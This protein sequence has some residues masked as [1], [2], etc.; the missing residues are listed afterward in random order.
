MTSM[1]VEVKDLKIGDIVQIQE[2]R[3]MGIT[4]MEVLEVQ[5]LGQGFGMYVKMTP[6]WMSNSV[7]TVRRRS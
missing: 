1:N 4:E 5:D 2:E 3:T 6:Y 7:V